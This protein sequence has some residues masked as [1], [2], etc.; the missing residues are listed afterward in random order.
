MHDRTIEL[1]RI[2]S[3]SADEV[4]HES[5]ER[6][7][8]CTR[9]VNPAHASST[10]ARLD[11]DDADDLSAARGVVLATIGSAVFWVIVAMAVM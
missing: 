3:C 11:E 7:S 2:A 5:M 9:M 10:R 6:S 1:A 8:V 4:P